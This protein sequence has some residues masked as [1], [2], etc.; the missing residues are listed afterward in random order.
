[1]TL[2]SSRFPPESEGCFPGKSSEPSSRLTRDIGEY[3][4]DLAHI[5]WINGEAR[6]LLVVRIWL[7]VAVAVFVC[8]NY[9]RELYLGGCPRLQRC[10][11][12]GNVLRC[13][14]ARPGW[15][16]RKLHDD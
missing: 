7:G 3:K 10:F 9:L 15:R 5:V 1:M 13:G 12:A 8:S 4:L 11:L 2:C 16:I 14:G 6:Q